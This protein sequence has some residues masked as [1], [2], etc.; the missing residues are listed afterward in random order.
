MIKIYTSFLLEKP[1]MI[2]PLKAKKK[3]QNI[4]QGQDFKNYLLNRL[5]NVR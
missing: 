1:K 3:V 4:I 2:E 5:K